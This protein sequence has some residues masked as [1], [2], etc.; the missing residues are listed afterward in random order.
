MSYCTELKS[1]L[2]STLPKKKCCKNA[3]YYGQE[4]FLPEKARE[5]DTDWKDFYY[6][7]NESKDVIKNENIK[8]H[9]CREAFIRGAFV[10]C[11]TVSDPEKSYHLEMKVENEKL[12][13]SLYEFLV[14]NSVAIKRRMIG[15]KH[16]L[17]I[18][19]ADD[20]VD[21]LFLMGASKEAFEMANGK[22]RRDF[23]NNANRH[24]NFETVNIQK[25]V[26]A[27]GESIHAIK[28]LKNAGRLKSLPDNLYE[29]AMLRIENE[30]LSIE[31]LAKLHKEKISKS[32]VNH[33]L[34]KL[35]EEA[36]KI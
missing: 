24:A 23:L 14:D 26:N 20:I 27:A 5:K 31:E 9:S 16:S 28:K 8:C 13:D 22:I 35:I 29:T 30:T 2:V 6:D 11:G 36:D 34:R 32:G 3:F 18:K 33:R 7:E 4:L 25:T 1:G 21:F 17:Y 12:A 19:K 15:K 10:G